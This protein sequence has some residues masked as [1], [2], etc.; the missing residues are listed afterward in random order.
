M[1]N[2]QWIVFQAV[3][4]SLTAVYQSTL[5][6]LWSKC[7]RLCFE[8]QHPTLLSLHKEFL[9]RDSGYFNSLKNRGVD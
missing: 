9:V 6:F 7:S 5:V 2:V 1:P 8:I 4:G 3:I